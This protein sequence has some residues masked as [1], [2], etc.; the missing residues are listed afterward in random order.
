MALRSPICTVVG[1]VDHGKSSIL[2]KIRRSNIVAGEAGKITQHIGASIIPLQNIKKIC[3]NLLQSMKMDFTIPG[4]L[5]IDTPGHAAFTHLRKRGGN[6]ADIA[7]LVVDVNE[8]FKPQTIESIEILKSYKTPFIVAANKI[9]LLHGWRSND[10]SIL[11]NIQNQSSDVATSIETKLYEIVGKLSEFGMDSERFDRVQDYTKQIA[12]VPVSAHTG[13]GIPELL[14][15]ISGLAQRF[16]EQCLQ[17]D[18]KGNAKGTILEI[19]EEKGLGITADVI[20]YDG[21]LKVNDTIVI[22]GIEK[23]TVTKVRALFEP[24]PLKEMRDKK[25]KFNSVKEV[26]AATGAKISAPELNGIVSGMPIRS[27]S[28]EEVEKVSQE[29]QN[30]VEEVL[31]ETEDDGIILKADT[32]GSL[33]ALT[34]LVRE[35]GYKVRKASVGP[36][37]KKDIV[38]AKSNLEKDP[39]TALVIGFNVYLMPD[40]KAPEGV[41]VITSDVIYKLV[42]DLDLFVTEQ[43]KAME[44]KSL[45]GLT[46]PCKLE[47]LKGY[48]FRQNNPA[49]VGCHILNGKAKV[50]MQLMKEDGT[51]ITDIKSMQ[52]EKDSAKEL[53]KNEQAAIAMNN[54]TV[55]RQINEGDIMYSFMTEQEY[56]KFKENKHLLSDKEKELLKEIC[57]IMRKE[58]AVWGV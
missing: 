6:L 16:L 19:K 33:E 53:N 51:P 17:C 37:S 13:E 1:H 20:L 49:I 55:G 18:V 14:M 42:D 35:Q 56:R 31:V 34:N 41:K 2:D 21:T 23:A 7:I 12:I 26:H 9:D 3:G 32:L 40:V 54:V 50:G 52:K 38:D 45:S 43:K 28:K 10:G 48:V 30:E 8:G 58:N 11:S 4:L 57:G 5:F 47:V 29:I 44:L 46:F 24:M 25:G 15:V 27:C 22:G 39:L 36:I